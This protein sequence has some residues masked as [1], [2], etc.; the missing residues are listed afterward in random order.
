MKQMFIELILDFTTHS[1][2]VICKEVFPP[3]FVFSNFDCTKDTIKFL[4]IER[5]HIVS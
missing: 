5:I 3:L 2:S 1:R 4:M